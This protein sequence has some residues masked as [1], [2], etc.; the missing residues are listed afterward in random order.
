MVSM[1]TKHAFQVLDGQGG[2]LR[3]EGARCLLLGILDG[4]NTLL[5]RG[6]E[7]D[8]MLARRGTLKAVVTSELPE[9]HQSEK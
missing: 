3:Q 6:R 7:I 4:D 5:N 9:T 1:K 2:T 8:K